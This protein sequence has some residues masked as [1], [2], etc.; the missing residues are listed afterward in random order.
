MS[1]LALLNEFLE[2]GGVD[3]SDHIRQATLTLDRSA[4]D[5]SA[6]GDGWMRNKG[7]QR[8]GTLNIEFLDDFDAASVDATLWAAYISTTGIIAYKVRPD[9][10]VASTSNPQ[11]AGN[12]LVNQHIVGG[13]LNEMAAKSLTLPLD[14]AAARTTA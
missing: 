4:L 3:L 14:G 13:S 1:T 2:L 11:Y 10:D 6:M 5:S 12:L 9:A 7:G 8:S